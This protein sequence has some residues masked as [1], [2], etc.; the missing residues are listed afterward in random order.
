MIAHPDQFPP[1]QLETALE[2]LSSTPDTLDVS[3]FE[4]LNGG[5]LWTVT[6]P[7]AS[8]DVASLDLDA[9]GLVGTEL[10][11]TVSEETSGG[12][13]SGSFYL[14][15]NGGSSA[16]FPID[17]EGVFLSTEDME[18]NGTGRSEPLQWNAAE[19]DVRVAIE[20]LLPNYASPG[21]IHIPFLKQVGFI[22]TSTLARAVATRTMLSVQIWP[23]RKSYDVRKF[24]L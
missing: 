21:N 18:H 22:R 2:S 14:Y 8:G 20:G 11:A 5:S 6:F 7:A 24:R 16:G 17:A 15:S 9:A 19:D 13:L 23:A 1:Q 4:L 3:R 10:H 12:G